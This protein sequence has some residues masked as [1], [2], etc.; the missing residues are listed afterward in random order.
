MNSQNSKTSDSHRVILN[1]TDRI[2][3]RRKY[4]YGTLS[5]LSIYSTQKNIKKSNKNKKFKIL[6]PTWHEELELPDGLYSVS[7]IQ[8]YP[9]YIFKRH[10]TALY[11]PSIRIYIN[12]IENRITLS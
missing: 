12:E 1:F 2:D 7:D 4:K 11:N 5:N 9:K 10:E 3:L 8:D 6:D